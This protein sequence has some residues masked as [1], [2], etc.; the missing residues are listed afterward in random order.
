MEGKNTNLPKTVFSLY[1]LMDFMSPRNASNDY[2][3]DHVVG[4]NSKA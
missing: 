3:S 1:S 4:K 2:A